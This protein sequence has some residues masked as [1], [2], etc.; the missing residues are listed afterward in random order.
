M[1]LR[2]TQLIRLLARLP[3]ELLAPIHQRLRSIDIDLDVAVNVLDTE[4]LVIDRPEGSKDE[5]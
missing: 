4:D 3:S 1:L 5:V 2:P